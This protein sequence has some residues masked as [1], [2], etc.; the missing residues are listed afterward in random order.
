MDAGSSPW[1]RRHRPARAWSRWVVAMAAAMLAHVHTVALDAPPA[2]PQAQLAA[3]RPRAAARGGRSVLPV[4]G[5]LRLAGGAGRGGSG[6]ICGGGVRAEEDAGCGRGDVPRSPT[7]PPA[8]RHG[9][10]ASSLRL[11]GGWWGSGA[12]GGA[13]QG[14][15]VTGGGG[16]TEAGVYRTLAT[17]GHTHM[18]YYGFMCDLRATSPCP[19][20]PD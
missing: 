8:G 5:V 14:G 12:A 7:E 6:D 19:P 2:Q 18:S 13:G 20:H 10:A 4:C 16:D 11:A 1:P 9:S 3:C 15:A 17:T